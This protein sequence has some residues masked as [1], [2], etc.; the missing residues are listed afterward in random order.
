[1]YV[2][3]DQ[4]QNTKD[5]RKEGEQRETFIISRLDIPPSRLRAADDSQFNNLFHLFIY[6]ISFRKRGNTY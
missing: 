5:G 1:M 3:R 6:F 4:P 2:A